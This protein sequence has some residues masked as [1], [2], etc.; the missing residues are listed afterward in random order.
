MAKRTDDRASAS[1]AGRTLVF[2]DHFEGD[3]LD[4]GVWVPHYL[5]AWSSRAASAASYELRDSC[6]HLTI[7]VE[8][9]VWCEGDHEPPIRVS[10]LQTGTWSGPVGSTRGQQ[11]FRAGQ[12]VREEQPTQ[13][14]FTPDHGWVGL[15]A[16]ATLSR[17]SMVS[18]WMVGR[19]QVPEECAEI[20]VT[21]VFGDTVE[22]QSG[23]TSAAVG[24]GLHR[25]R[26]LRV[27]EDFVATRL[28]IDPA[29]WH[30]YAVDWTP[31]R[32]VFSVDG[33]V[34]RTC[35]GPPAYPL[36]LMLAVFDFPERSDGTD[37]D[38]VP[39]LVVDWVRGSA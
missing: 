17:R 20:C 33:A 24:Q 19:E 38:A 18:L 35:V 30:V 36:Q 27:T 13:W 23:V 28:P 22:Q 1:P 3:A 39:E 15:R 16:R 37:A 2:E 9:P 4:A 26:D 8:H 6:L 7:P 11:P 14:G 31:E 25:F 5:P 12:T 10:G 34:T 21:E 32:A 29:E